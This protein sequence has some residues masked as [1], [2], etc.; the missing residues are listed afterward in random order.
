MDTFNQVA[1]YVLSLVLV[2]VSLLAAWELIALV[3]WMVRLW[4]QR[5]RGE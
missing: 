5:L 4:R 2:V 3:G 1:F